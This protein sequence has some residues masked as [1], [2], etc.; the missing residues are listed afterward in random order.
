MFRSQPPISYCQFVPE[1]GPLAW[2]Q[3]GQQ[4]FCW[5]WH[6]G[7]YAVAQVAYQQFVTVQYGASLHIVLTRLGRVQSPA[8]VLL[9]R[10]DD[11]CACA[12]LQVLDLATGAVIRTLPGVRHWVEW[13]QQQQQ[14]PGRH[15]CDETTSQCTEHVQGMLP[16][17]ADTQQVANP[18]HWLS[19]SS[20]GGLQPITHSTSFQA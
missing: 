10:S 11:W 4:L 7:M 13:Q 5:K 6:S 3:A 16:A 14:Q 18:R 20:S 8:G 15:L 9:C 17:G 12:V 2:R 19:C 1:L